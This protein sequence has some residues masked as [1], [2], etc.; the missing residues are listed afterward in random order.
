M[1]PRNQK[2]SHSLYRVEGKNREKTLTRKAI[3]GEASAF[4]LLY[5]IYQPKIYRF[6]ILKISHREEA[7][8]LTHQ[9]FLTAWEKLDTFEY[10][11][12]PLSS[13][14]FR[15]A[16]NKVIDHY[17]TRKSQVSIDEVPEE[18]LGITEEDASDAVTKRMN[19]QKVW[20]ALKQ[21]SEEQ[22]EV[23]VLRFVEELT[24]KEIAD[25]TSKT[26]GAARVLQHRAIK[27]L[28]ELIHD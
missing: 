3:E 12:L 5:D 21:L 25:V 1:T 20:D 23:L 22:Q 7:E 9:V 11:D 10:Q 19:L 24:Y 15:I 2:G 4:G 28:K 27:R 26:P 16:R 8:D 14:L 18:I 13:W 17:R 6:V